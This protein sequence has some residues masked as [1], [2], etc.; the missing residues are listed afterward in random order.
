[1]FG[2][3]EKEFCTGDVETRAQHTYKDIEIVHHGNGLTLLVHTCLISVHMLQFYNVGLDHVP[4]VVAPAP[5][6]HTETQ[7]PLEAPPSESWQA[8]VHSRGNDGAG[9]KFSAK[10]IAHVVQHPSQS[11]MLGNRE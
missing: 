7:I 10:S 8:H 1:M 3:E 6:K 4:P 2:T 5:G 11:G 9:V